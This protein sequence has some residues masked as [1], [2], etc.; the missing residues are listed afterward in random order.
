MEN[1]VFVIYVNGK[2]VKYFE[3]SES[4]RVSNEILNDTTLVWVE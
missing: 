4:D 2:K 1:G 3:E